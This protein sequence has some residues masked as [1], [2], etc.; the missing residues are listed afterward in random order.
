MSK[1]QEFISEKVCWRCKEIVH[2]TVTE[3]CPNCGAYNSKKKPK[4]PELVQAEKEEKIRKLLSGEIDGQY[5]DKGFCI[6]DGVKMT[7]DEYHSPEFQ[8]KLN[9]KRFAAMNK[10]RASK[11]EE[12]RAKGTHTK[13]EWMTLIEEFEHRC[14]RCGNVPEDGLTKDHIEMIARGGSDTIDNIQPLCRQCNSAQE[15]FNWVEWRRENGFGLGT[16]CFCW[17]R[18]I[19]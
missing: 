9:K 7:Y 3:W 4:P 15:Q 1:E 16:N 2:P 12:A 11:M 10:A 19:S 8:K 18:R 5:F 17:M 13:K 14:L 6:I